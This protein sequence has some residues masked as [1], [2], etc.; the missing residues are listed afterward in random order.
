MSEKGRPPLEITS[1]TG[2]QITAI[3]ID[4]LLLAIDERLQ[5][6]NEMVLAF[7]HTLHSWKSDC[8]K[9][10]M[11]RCMTVVSFGGENNI[12]RISCALLLLSQS[13]ERVY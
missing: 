12:C 4:V 9:K 3:R 8:S 11:K 7:F 1:R 13:Q 2:V 5:R 10:E 6:M